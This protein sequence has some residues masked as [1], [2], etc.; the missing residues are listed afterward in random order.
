MTAKLYFGNFTK[1][2][3]KPVNFLFAV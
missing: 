2:F 1:S 3:D